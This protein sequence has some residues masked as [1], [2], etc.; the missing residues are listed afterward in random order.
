MYELRTVIP[1]ETLNI[2][3][4]LITI[5]FKS[6]FP[7]GGHKKK[8]ALLLLKIILDKFLKRSHLI[9][10]TLSGNEIF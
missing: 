4:E 3:T 10:R 1:N 8:I 5:V 2:A 6:I 7:S 9:L